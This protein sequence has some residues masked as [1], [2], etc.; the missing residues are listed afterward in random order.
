MVPAESV[1]EAEGPL[2]AQAV[3]EEILS[4]PSPPLAVPER[5]LVGSP[6]APPVSEPPAERTTGEPS[7]AEGE[8]EETIGGSPGPSPSRPFGALV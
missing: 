1:T 6:D 7:T 5:L 3:S 8:P 4:A 2:V